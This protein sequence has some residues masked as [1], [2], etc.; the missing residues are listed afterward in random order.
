[1]R[2]P[3]VTRDPLTLR[4][5]PSHSAPTD[6]AQKRG[7]VRACE[8]ANWCEEN[9]QIAQKNRD[10]ALLRINDVQA[11]LLDFLAE[12]WARGFPVQCLIPKGRQM[13]VT[14]FWQAINFALCV[15][16]ARKGKAFRAATVAHIEESATQIFNMS[17]RFERLL[18]EAWS[19][20]LD[21]RQKGH[22]AWD[23]G[24]AI[25]I[26]SAQLGDAALKGVTIN[27][28]HGSEVANWADRGV[29]PSALWTSGMGALTPGPESIVAL[30]STAKGRDPFFHRMIEQALKGESPYAVVFLP[31]YLSPEYKLSWKDYRTVRVARGWELPDRFQPTDDERDMVAMIQSIEIGR[32]QEWWK[33]PVSLTEEQLIWRRA[34]IEELDGKVEVFKRYFPATLEECFSSTEYS[35]FPPEVV[36][37]LWGRQKDP[38]W[39]G[40]AVVRGER[41]VWTNDP[42]GATIVWKQPIP[43]HNYVIGA[44]VSEGLVAGDAQAAYV[45][46][47]D[48]HEV[49]A[50]IHCRVD[51][52]LYAE[53]LIALGFYYNVALVA[54]EN[55]FS[56]HVAGRIQER[57]YPRC[58][59]H[60][61]P[62]VVRHRPS[63]PGFSTNK[64]TRRVIL[65]VLAAVFRDD[66]VRVYD[67]GFATEAGNF[68]WDERKKGWAA[69]ASKTDDRVIALAIAI[70]LCGWRKDDGTKLPPLHEAAPKEVLDAG[71]LAWQRERARMKRK[72][73][74][75]AQQGG[76]CVL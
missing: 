38:T 48:D 46:D 62:D 47:A 16:W 23:S 59:W 74:E 49:V 56:P 41:A 29:D 7:V 17:R 55:T 75:K 13:G 3:W 26:V 5:T 22:L 14:T 52:D 39:R 72:A 33:H 37:R 2:T 15:L 76:G 18:P 57:G 40:S 11:I 19:L 20:T 65:E 61:D 42:K 36:D 25:Y 70:Y 44:D 58:H 24:S 64:K 32:G 53:D 4:W 12:C 63:K 21:T 9:L 73:R 45:V 34:K 67:K 28:I 69:P 71:E 50:A 43:G 68:V 54:V 60:R 8:V 1:M 31:W 35:M 51:P 27:S 10:V 30:E 66:D 6:P